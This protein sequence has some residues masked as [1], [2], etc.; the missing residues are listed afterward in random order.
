MK[1]FDN[2][3]I[4]EKELTDEQFVNVCEYLVE[5]YENREGYDRVARVAEGTH[6]R[7]FCVGVFDVT[8]VIDGEYFVDDLPSDDF[9]NCT[10]ITYEEFEQ[11]LLNGSEDDE[12]WIEWNGGD[13]PVPEDTIVTCN[14]KGGYGYTDNAGFL[15]WDWIGS[16]TDIIKYRLHKP[17]EDSSES[18]NTNTKTSP[19]KPLE[20]I[21][22]RLVSIQKDLLEVI[23]E[24]GCNITVYND[25]ITINLED[26]YGDK[27]FT[28]RD[29]RHSVEDLQKLLEGVKL[30]KEFEGK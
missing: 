9:E 7:L 30:I 20:S 21:S 14:C 1:T 8:G 13:C 18:P 11:Y 16:P 5:N 26:D 17:S 4:E 24:V 6:D 15:T 25:E 3:Y 2:W 29:D 19:E 23:K 12:G 27:E 22:K 10:K 28:W